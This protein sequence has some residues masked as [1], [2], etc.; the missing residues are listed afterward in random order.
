MQKLS[1]RQQTII[2][3]IHHQE[4]YSIDELAQYFNATAQTTRRDINQLC[5]VGLACRHHG[6]VG[7][8]VTLANRSYVS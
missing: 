3:M 8:P 5:A 1:L 6:G 4:Y 2:D 7:L